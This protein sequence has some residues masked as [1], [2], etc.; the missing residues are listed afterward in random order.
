MYQHLTNN[1]VSS[2]IV[3]FQHSEL[4]S[5]QE[6]KSLEFDEGVEYKDW[7]LPEDY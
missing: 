1:D 4:V 7:G 5:E 6:Q 2:Y 3:D